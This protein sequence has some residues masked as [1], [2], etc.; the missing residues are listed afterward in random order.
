ML[1]H[2][3]HVGFEQR[4]IIGVARDWLRLVQIV[5][6][7]MQRSARRDRDAKWANR[8][9]IGKVDGDGYVGVAL[10]GV[11]DAGRLVRDEGTP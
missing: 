3:R 4:G 9:A 1:G 10:S 7:Q 8:L 2:D 6:A 11:K 5:E